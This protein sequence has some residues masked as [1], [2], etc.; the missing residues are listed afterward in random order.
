MDKVRPE[1]FRKKSRWKV[2]LP[3]IWIP[4]MCCNI[5]VND[6]EIVVLKGIII[7]REPNLTLFLHRFAM[8]EKVSGWAEACA[9]FL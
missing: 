2:H 5:N 3:L 9:W 6:V 1:F 8:W 7:P 4:P